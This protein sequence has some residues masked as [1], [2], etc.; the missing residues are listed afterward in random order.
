MK[1]FFPWSNIP[2][3]VVCRLYD[4]TNHG[5]DE[6]T[7]INEH[8]LSNKVETLKN[9]GSGLSS[10]TNDNSSWC[11]KSQNSIEDLN[12]EIERLFLNN[13]NFG[14]TSFVYDR[15]VSLF[16]IFICILSYFVHK[17]SIKLV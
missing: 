5:F 8:A 14:F 1:Y 7:L 6:V 3:T 9:S 4:C 12:K 2:D 10:P 13:E 17:I 15:D 16:E 11:N